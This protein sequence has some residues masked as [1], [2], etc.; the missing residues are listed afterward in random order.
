MA[1][2]S[3]EIE[4]YLRD[5]IIRQYLPGEDPGNLSDELKLQECGVLTSVN[6][7][8][9]V[10]QVEDEYGVTFNAHEIATRFNSIPGKGPRSSDRGLIVRISS[11][12][13][14]ENAA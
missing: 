6:T 8:D 7:L 5:Q 3:S 14:A 10:T 13:G 11:I 12:G 1:R 2:A 9:F 4:S